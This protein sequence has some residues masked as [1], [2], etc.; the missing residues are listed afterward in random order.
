MCMCWQLSSSYPTSLSL[1]GNELWVGGGDGRLHVVDLSEGSLPSSAL[2]RIWC[3]IFF[4]AYNNNNNTSVEKKN[5][6]L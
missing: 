1:F 3:L 6:F 5:T 4:V 2:V